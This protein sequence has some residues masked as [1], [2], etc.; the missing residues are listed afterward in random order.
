MVVSSSSVFSLLLKGFQFTEAVVTVR[1]LHQAGAEIELHLCLVTLNE[2]A[3]RKQNGL[4]IRVPEQY[5]YRSARY[6]HKYA[7][8]NSKSGYKVRHSHAHTHTQKNI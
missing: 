3:K 7:I 2:A 1:G 6:I 5:V 8:T 4:R